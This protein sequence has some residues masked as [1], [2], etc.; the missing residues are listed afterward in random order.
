ME[1]G[2][3]HSW[4][5]VFPTFLGKTVSVTVKTLSA[6]NSVEPRHIKREK[7]SLSVDVCRLC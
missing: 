1:V 2:F 6:K 3:L 7:A 5:E 4:P